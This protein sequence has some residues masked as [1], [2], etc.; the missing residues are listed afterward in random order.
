MQLPVMFGKYELQKF[1]GGGMSQVYKATDTVLGR[2]VAVKVLTDEGC[3]DD[4]TKARFLMEARMSGNMIHDNIIR[5]HDYGEIGGRP[6]IV[7]EFLVGEDL[8]TAIDK[9]HTGD[10]KQRLGIA[11]QAARALG[12]VHSKNIIH[13]DI[14][15]ENLH[16]DE[17]GR[18]RLMD[19]GIAKTQ[20]FNITREGFAIGTP[21]YMAP[22][23]VLGKPVT[24]A[25]DIYAFGILL[26]EMLTGVKPVVGDSVEALFY[27][28][29]HQ[30][31]D[32]APLEQAGVPRELVNLVN[33][34][35]AK[36]P[37]ERPSSFEAVISE[38]E[39]ILKRLDA[40]AAQPAPPPSRTH[41]QPA[42]APA[43]AVPP[44][45]S[46]MP[47]VAIAAAFV[48]AAGVL[49][50]LYLSKAGPATDHKTPGGDSGKPAGPPPVIQDSFG[51]MILVPGG[52]FLS[53]ANKVVKDL[54]PFYIDKTE[55]SNG[56]W[57]RFAQ[58]LGK[59][60]TSKPAD[61]PVTDITYDE[62]A[63]YCTW[64]HK[65]IP[66]GDEWEKAA[67]GTVGWAYPW[68]N[69]P[70]PGKANV[71]GNTSSPPG[72]QPVDT[73]LGA[74]PSGILN[75]A[76]NAWEWVNEDRKPL[77]QSLELFKFMNA[78]MNEHWTAIRG[79]AYDSDVSNAVTFEMST[80]P[81]RLKGAAIG[82]RC[83]KDA[84]RQA[85]MNRRPTP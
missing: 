65:R 47:L 4:D 70:D 42:P 24:P 10:L 83:A 54:P 37:E 69:E 79:G 35:A 84:P 36:K 7:M 27:L 22:E 43:P 72:L 9:G 53:G 59:T 82:F 77:P 68:G 32:M 75:I 5:I 55:V 34:C 80:V 45:R 46:V 78:T 60:T 16:I 76:G 71:K 50:T 57:N 73:P 52:S 11:L 51:E 49:A 56:M 12:F 33:R 1:L 67:R 21:Y 62:A 39:A 30:P 2:I 41:E 63:E 74:T 81:A 31:L 85:A 14:K 28:I 48:I 18:V 17:S 15:P 29:L 6:Y 26:Y 3:R 44:R 61:L 13:R 40:P 25:A 20:N 66:T 38:L 8:R 23:Q 19:F 58:A 64:A